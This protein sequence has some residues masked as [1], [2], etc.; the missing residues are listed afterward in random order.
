MEGKGR[1]KIKQD[2]WQTY[3]RLRDRIKTMQLGESVGLALCAAR[4]AAHTT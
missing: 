2:S 4:R 1:G 3:T